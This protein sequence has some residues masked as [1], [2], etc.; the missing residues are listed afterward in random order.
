VARSRR[1]AAGVAATASLA[2]LL[3]VFVLMAFDP[4]ITMRGAADLLFA[5]LALALAAP[6]RAPD[7]RVA[8]PDDV[9]VFRVPPRP[10]TPEL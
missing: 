8:P 10:R 2:S 9:A 4:H 5:L 1:D 3:A 6:S 7:G